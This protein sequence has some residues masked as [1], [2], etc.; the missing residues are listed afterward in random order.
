MIRD[1]SELKERWLS[2]SS[3]CLLLNKDLSRISLMLWSIK[4]AYGLIMV[5]HWQ[6]SFN[7]FVFGSRER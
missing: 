2:I 1:S 6:R 7:I 3:P 4:R 5:R